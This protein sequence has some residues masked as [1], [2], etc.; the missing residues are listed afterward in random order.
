MT[1]DDRMRLRLL[2]K[3]EELFGPEEAD[4]LMGEFSHPEW[5]DVATRSDLRELGLE[6]RGEMS[7]LRGEMSELRGEMSELR[8]EVRSLGGELRAE[9]HASI[10]NQTWHLVTFVCAFN[11][12]LVAVCGVVVATL[13]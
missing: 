12:V 8:G 2:P 9:M 11:A 1:L 10:R 13:I 3:L 4:A 5:G 6:L 7:E